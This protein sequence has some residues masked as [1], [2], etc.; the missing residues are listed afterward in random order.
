MHSEDSPAG[1][2]G[3]RTAGQRTGD[4]CMDAALARF[5]GTWGRRNEQQV[6]D[7]LTRQVEALGLTRDGFRL[8]VDEFLRKYGKLEMASLQTETA[9]KALAK[10]QDI[11][12][13]ICGID[14]RFRSVAGLNTIFASWSANDY[15]GA[16]LPTGEQLL[17]H[18]GK[19]KAGAVTCER[20]GG[21]HANSS[22][23]AQQPVAPVKQAPSPRAVFIPVDPAR[24]P[25]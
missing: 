24:T 15:R 21:T 3:H 13:S 2:A 5:E 8:L 7:G 4:V 19:M 22:G 10:A 20:K 23:G 14:R 12:L 18:A 6:V 25:F 11:V 16:S 17:E 9:T 1:A